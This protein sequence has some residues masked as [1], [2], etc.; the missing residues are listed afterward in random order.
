MA[1]RALVRKYAC[2]GRLFVERPGLVR[3]GLPE[4]PMFHRTLISRT[5]CVF[6]LALLL[7]ATATSEATAAGIVGYRNDTNQVIVVQT[8]MTVNTVMRRS[9][10][11]TLFPGE[12]ALDGLIGAGTRRITIYDPKKPN[13][14]LFQGDVTS[15]D[16]AVYSIQAETTVMVKGQPPTPPKVKLVSIPLPNSPQKVMRPGMGGGPPPAKPGSAPPQ[17]PKKP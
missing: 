1:E 15:N 9:K 7:A 12:V 11:Q 17:P 2:C 6:G 16:D 5:A 3:A 4:F 8:V 13:A 10:P 14:P